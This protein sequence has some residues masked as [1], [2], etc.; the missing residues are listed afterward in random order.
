MTAANTAYGEGWFAH[1]RG[2]DILECPYNMVSPE[3]IAWVEGWNDYGDE[4]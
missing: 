3:G 1:A 4:S 2:I